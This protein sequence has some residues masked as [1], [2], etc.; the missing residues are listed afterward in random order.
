M[1]ANHKGYATMLMLSLGILAAACLLATPASA[2]PMYKGTFTLTN[3][4][5]WGQTVIPPGEY[6]ITLDQQTRTVVICDAG[7]H[8][9]AR[10]TATIS[11]DSQTSDSKLLIYANGD[12]RAV[13]S[14][15]L[16]GFGEIFVSGRQA[17]ASRRAAEE[18][19]NQEAVPIEG[20]RVAEK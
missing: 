15:R 17:A 7:N 5:H 6:T 9:V 11:P 8:V 13:Y 10:Q 18:T 3:V 4:V 19:G 1:K 14:M 20:S 12:Q 2:N 16:A